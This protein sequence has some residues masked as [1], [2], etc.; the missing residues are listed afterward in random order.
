M[1]FQIFSSFVFAATAGSFANADSLR[2]NLRSTS[3]A[4]EDHRRSLAGEI[5]RPGS[6]GRGFTE[7]EECTV[8]VAQL[9]AIEPGTIEDTVI[10]CQSKSDD[11]TL[12]TRK[13]TGTSDQVTSLHAMFEANQVV[14]G[15][16]ILKHGRGAYYDESDITLPAGLVVANNIRQ[17]IRKRDDRRLSDLV[18]DKPILVVRVKDS[19]GKVHPDS[20]ITMSQNIFGGGGDQVNLKSQLFACSHE[21][22]NVLP[23]FIADSDLQVAGAP[24]VIEIT[25]DIEIDD[26]SQNSRYV[27]KN[28]IQNKAQEVL[29]FSLPGPYEQVMFSL[30][31]CYQDCGWAAYAYINSW[32]SVYQSNYYYMP[33]VQIHELGHNFGLAHSGGMNNQAY[34]DHTGLMGNPLYSDEIGKMCYNAAKNWQ[35]GWYD[36]AKYALATNDGQGSFPNTELS[37]VGVA[38]YNI[39]GSKPVTVKLETGTSTDYFIGFNRATKANSQNDEAD[40]EV[41]VTTSGNNGESYSQSYLKATLQQGESYTIA[42]GSLTSL[43]ITATAIDLSSDPGVATICVAYGSSTCT[44]NPVTPDPTPAPTKQPTPS[45][46]TAPTS[47]PTSFPTTPAT[48]APTSFPTTPAPTPVPTSAPT[49]SPITPGTCSVLDFE[50]A[51]TGGTDGWTTGGSCTTGTFVIGT[52]NE[53]T[54]SGVTTQVGGD[55]T[56]PGGTTGKALYTQP[57]SSAGVQDVDGGECFAI[58]PSWSVPVDSELSAWYFFGQR[59]EGDDPDGDY[60]KL[61]ISL[62][63]G[64]SWAEMVSIGDVTIDAVWTEATE[65]LIPAGSSVQLRIKASDGSGPGDL[66]EAGIDDV[67]ICPLGTGEPTTSPTHEP[68]SDPTKNPTPQPTS[69]PT[70]LPSAAPSSPPTPLPTN[71]PVITSSPIPEPTSDPTKNPTPQPTSSPTDLPTAAPSSPPTPLPTNAPVITLSPT[72]GPTLSPTAGPTS[73]PTAKVTISPTA[74]EPPAVAITATYD[75][76]VGA[77]MCFIAGSS[78]TSSNILLDGKANNKEPNS[79]NTIDQCLD[80]SNGSWH[81]D[82]SV[83]ALTVSST[84]GGLLRAGK[85]AKIEATFWAWNTGSTDMVDF[86]YCADPNASTPNWTWIYSHRPSR[87]GLTTFPVEYTIPDNGI[88]AHAIRVQI[89]YYGSADACSAGSWND[90]DDLVFPVAAASSPI[91]GS[92]IAEPAALP[93]VDPVSSSTCA[94]ISNRRR[95]SLALTSGICNWIK[96]GRT[97]GCYPA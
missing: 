37:M 15:E 80:G 47:A 97:R 9:L 89:R 38:D 87:G 8:L 79:S 56:T 64:S 96:R 90:R 3:I 39:R 28:A 10:E 77:P 72:A 14:S 11:G 50:S 17:D 21:K 44:P 81:G 4:N 6:G 36:D 66:V 25:L 12:R 52:P 22:L 94:S 16:T 53:I 59:D 60:F 51:N 85:V 95:C 32:M 41:T 45:P 35:I 75:T 26:S 78:C 65:P 83:D 2:N 82:E 57:N 19:V 58:S 63:G 13:I 42:S 73:S 34:T 7:E 70:D 23:G 93:L 24:G 91:T 54:N 71:A 68:T 5:K 84:S 33:G 46:T 20:A 30:E 67:V 40:N 69:S 61:E 49:S 86:F 62:D 43:T 18:G 29:G 92:I 74:A 27:V 31:R 1:K 76:N 48:S 55:H 88:G